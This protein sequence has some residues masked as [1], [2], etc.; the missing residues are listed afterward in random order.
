MNRMTAKHVDC[1][2]AKLVL[3]NLVKLHLTKFKSLRDNHDV[4]V[5]KLIIN[6][7]DLI[8]CDSPLLDGN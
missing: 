7:F 1:L 5:V 3:V 4:I 2:T 6:N 8:V